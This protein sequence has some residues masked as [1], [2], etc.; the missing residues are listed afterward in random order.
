M[1]VK[2]SDILSSKEK[3][4]VDMGLYLIENNSTVRKTAEKFGI[5]KS[6]VHK[7]LVVSLKK[8]D[9]E[10]Y[11]KSC[12]VMQKNKSERHLRGGMATKLKYMNYK[13]RK[14]TI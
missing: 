8:I 13:R 9:Y 5:S 1:K 3:L 6:T 11:K 4:I 14:E 12:S 7:N 10:L 2:E